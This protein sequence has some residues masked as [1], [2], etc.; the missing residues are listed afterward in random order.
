[1]RFLERFSV[2]ALRRFCASVLAGGAL[3][4]AAPPPAAADPTFWKSEWPNTDFSRTI[5]GSWGE[6]ISGGPPKDG[7]PALS[8]PSFVR[9]ASESR[10]EGRE[11]VITVEIDGQ[12]PRAYPIRYLTWHEIVNDRIGGVPVAVTFCP[13]CNSGIVFDRRVN[14]RVLTFGV[15][16][17]L[18]NS[19]MIMFDR[20]TESWW[21]QAIGTGIVG[22]YTGMEL[23]QIPAW[24]ESWDQFRARNPDGLVM[25]EPSW[26]RSY[27]SN[28][29]RG[30]D[31][32]RRPFLYS[33]EMPPHGIPPL[34]RVVR[35]GDRAWPLARVSEAGE[36]REAGVTISWQ[37]GQASA[38]DSGRIGKGRDVGSIRVRDAQGRDVAHDVMF[39]FAFHAFWPDGEWMLN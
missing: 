15:S 4:L 10:I 34:A 24:M 21:Q 23:T 7:I 36:L 17:K 14:G 18:R 30:Y 35:V 6:I 31:S 28:P 26:N 2:Q 33:G 13:L 39:A 37:S 3:A 32:S 16:G 12:A 5:V 19:D 20:E 8:D 25:N 27:G 22:R 11:P 9:V 29:Y 38:L 1:M